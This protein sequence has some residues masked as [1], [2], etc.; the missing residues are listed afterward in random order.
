MSP[1][2]VAVGYAVAGALAVALVALPMVPLWSSWFGTVTDFRDYAR[3]TRPALIGLFKAEGPAPVAA[4]VRSEASTLPEGQFI[5]LADPGKNVLA[6]T[7]GAWPAGV[8]DASVRET[9]VWTD[10]NS[11]MPAFVAW[12]DILPGGYHLLMGR[13]SVDTVRDLQIGAVGAIVT[14]ILLGAVVA[15]LLAR[16]ANAVR[17]SDERY[18]RVILASEA[19][20]WEWDVV[21]D[22]YY[23]S[24]ALLELCGFPP[25][26]TF[27]G[28]EDFM[29][30][31][32]FVRE[33]LVRY[34][35]AVRQLFAEGG[36]RLSMEVRRVDG[37]ETR[38]VNLVGMCFRDEKGRPV[39]WTG[40][41]TDITERKRAE[42]ASRE[43]QGRHERAMLA[44]E[45]G[46]FDWNV[47]TDEY[48]VSPAMLE[49]NGFPPDTTF[50]GREDFIRRTPFFPE[51]RAAYQ[52]AVRELFASGG[53]RVSME[54]RRLGDGE[55]R[56]FNIAG[57]CFRDAE[58]RVV[59]WTGSSTEIT[60]RKRAELDLRQSEQRY[61]LA[62]EAAA[63]GH[64]DW[65]F[66]TGEFYISPR[67]KQ[68]VGHAPDA[69][70]AG[71]D[72][73]VRRFP[74][75]PEDRRRWED[76][77]AAHFAGREAIFKM[78]VRAVVNGETRWLAF[79]FIATRDA[80]GR[81]VRWTGSIADIN[82]R[83]SAEEARR[84]SEERHALALEASDEG[85]FDLDFETGEIFVSARMNEIYGFPRRAENADRVEYFKRIPLHPDDGQLLAD[86][87]GEFEARTR[88]KIAEGPQHHEF[89]YRILR[90]H[91]RELRWIHARWMIISDA[92]GVARRVV[93]VVSD[94]T[95]RKVA[96]ETLRA[97][98]SRFRTLVQL[99]AGGFWEQDENF[100]Y[101]PSTYLHHITTYG[102]EY[103][104]GKTRWE[105]PGDLTPL[106]GSWDE[107]KADLE[108]HRP[109]R[110]FEY[111]RV[112][113]DGQLGYYSASGMPI[114]DDHGV[115][116][117]YYGVLMDITERKHAEEA[118]RESERRYERA[119]FA[120]RAGYWDY[121]L[122]TDEYYLSPAMLELA[123]FM[124]DTIFSGRDDFIRRAPF[125]PPGERENYLHAV[126]EL[127]VGG[128]TRL[129]REVRL[130]VDG[131]I[132]WISM[133]GMC[134]R[135]AAGKVSRW[136]GFATDITQ[137][138]HAEEDLR[139]MEDRLRLAQRLEGMGTLAG[140][141]AHDFNNI[142][143]AVLGYGEMAMRSAKKGSRLRRDLDSIMAAGERGRALV[144][145]V[146]AFS[147]SGV[148]ERA[149][150]HVEAVV[151]EVLD[152]VAARLPANV[153]IE[154]RLR[155][156]R[157]AMLGDSTQVHQVVMNLA[158]NGVQAMPKGGVL[159]VALEV[160]RFETPRPATI[161]SIAADDYIVLRVS[162][163]GTGIPADVLDRMF[164]PFF[165]T[166]EVGV[167][168]GLGLSLVHGIVTSVGGA[169]EVATE[170]G[171]GSAF[172]VY[173][174]RSG[175]ATEKSAEV[176]GP[177]PR[178]RGQR[179]LVVDDEEPLVRLT[180]ARLEHLGYSAVGFTS[181]AN[182]LQ[183]FGANPGRFDAILT[184]E[185]M[186]GITGSKVIEEVRRINASIPILL[187]SGFV[188]AA[189]A[190]KARE[191]GA[192]D[193]LKKPVL[194]RELA[195]SLARALQP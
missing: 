114:F 55:T 130:L 182:A 34:E 110:D 138:K 113:R 26:T 38:W 33:D 111:R 103:R 152:Q 49:Q 131:E 12:H 94:I 37:D 84:L 43:S 137:R 97:S 99:N 147:R 148:A 5:V 108:A 140:G 128:G 170:L 127:F 176:E 166:K 96:L 91:A 188:S 16:R 175:D 101:L 59:R 145:R 58:G 15:W 14:L 123:G 164:D 74:F 95:D 150:V 183:E 60:E 46:F 161:G 57:M 93:G 112:R 186:P 171:K 100:R 139:K 125:Y 69:T 190:Q 169:I 9:P 159:R 19:G 11:R 65:D 42:E 194:E 193:V 32:P 98:E 54:V 185:R 76:A 6:G 143:G 81:V 133:E 44:S 135:D 105:L 50:A 154:P 151:R 80:A 173:L 23:V 67:M 24:P 82:D 115:F 63:D 160:V 149:P 156:G 77:I 40:S 129:T 168:S 142:L 51:D 174:R 179:V 31:A 29:R 35:Q 7:L 21:K 41:A 180:S 172:T 165:T 68:I 155:A 92:D 153:S 126:R 191:L 39:R 90:G 83:K 56:W 121:D 134:L 10:P 18:E 4:A 187:M 162:D 124:P 141:I 122:V 3:K 85:H 70:F 120:S 89:E 1:W 64:M 8:P 104:V 163:S 72:D 87:V 109:F 157:A 66:V 17:S 189:A 53:S 75:H 158:S 132:R 2:R 61:A 73:W 167:G 27:T 28:R 116:K 78:D 106:S 45:A 102:N 62:M 119:M 178:G 25:G 146:L 136:T 86:T 195:T 47:V 107:H 79:N 22:A 36:S 30:R 144:D 88:G 20:L 181:S 13:K 177:L 192:N 118:L 71:R 48:Y 184:D 52:K 117:G